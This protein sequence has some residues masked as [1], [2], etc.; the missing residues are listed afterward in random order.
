MA[1]AP[2]QPSAVSLAEAVSLVEPLPAVVE[3][4][5]SHSEATLGAGSGENSFYP[6]FALFRLHISAFQTWI[7]NRPRKRF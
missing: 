5:S 3:P 2:S 7:R 4:A 6:F 1:A